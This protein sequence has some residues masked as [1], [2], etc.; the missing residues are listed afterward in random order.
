MTMAVHVPLNDAIKSAGDPAKIDI[1][2]VRAAFNAARWE[3]WN[4][5]RVAGSAGAFGRLAWAL[6]L[7]SRVGG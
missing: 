4:L 5:V 2:Q 6:V 7:Q 3:A 1:Q